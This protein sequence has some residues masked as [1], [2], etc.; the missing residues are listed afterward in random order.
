MLLY[1]NQDLQRLVEQPLNEQP[2]A[3]IKSPRNAVSPIEFQFVRNGIIIDPDPDYTSGSLT[4]GYWYKTTVHSAG[5]FTSVSSTGASANA[6]NAVWQAIGT[7][8]TSWGGDTLKRCDSSGELFSLRWTVKDDQDFNGDTLAY[9]TTFTKYGTGTSTIYRGVTNYNTTGINTLLGIGSG[10]GEVQTILMAELKWYGAQADKTNWI[11]LYLRNDIYKTGDGVPVSGETLYVT[12]VNSK[13]GVVTLAGSGSVTITESP[14]GTFTFTSSASSS[15]DVYTYTDNTFTGD[16]TIGN[17][18]IQPDDG[19]GV[20]QITADAGAGAGGA[21]RA[22]SGVLYV[23]GVDWGVFNFSTGLISG[24][25]LGG[26]IDLAAQVF[27]GTWQTGEWD[28]TFLGL[29][30]GG[31]VRARVQASDDASTTGHRFM[32]FGL[33]TTCGVNGGIATTSTDTANALFIE[34]NYFDNNGSI[35]GECYLQNGGSERSFNAQYAQTSTA[36][37]ATLVAGTVTLSS[38]SI[39]DF[40]RDHTGAALI[41][42]RFKFSGLVG[43]SQGAGTLANGTWYYVKT[44]PTANSFTFSTGVG[45]TGTTVTGSATAANG[46]VQRGGYGNISLAGPVTITA[47][48]YDDPNT[49]SDTALEIKNDKASHSLEV[50]L[51]NDAGNGTILNFSAAFRMGYDWGGGLGTTPDTLFFISP[52]QTGN[53][54]AFQMQSDDRV[55]IGYTTPH[56][57]AGALDVNGTVTATAFSGSGAGL[58]FGANVAAFLA[59]P[60]SA[61]LAAALTDESG[62]GGVVF[63]VAPTVE[64]PVIT[65]ASGAATLTTGTAPGLPDQ[66]FIF[67][68]G[69]SNSTTDPKISVAGTGTDISINIIPKGAGYLQVNTEAVLTDENS[70]TVANKTMSGASNTFT[71][72]PISTAISGLGTGIATALAVNTGSAGA[73]VLFNGALGTPSS[74]T[75]TNCTFP[76]LNQSTTGSAASISISGQSGLVT[77]TGLASTN[78]IKTVRDAADTILELGGSYT[79]TGTWTNM[80]L[81][82]PALGTPSAIVLT[83]ATG[84]PTGI[85]LTKAQLNTIVSDD[86]PAYVG[87]ANTFTAAQTFTGVIT[88]NLSAIALL[89]SIHT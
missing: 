40:V 77:L 20:A 31:V 74:G 27:D 50:L 71:N 57:A 80:V 14:S 68:P 54:P 15:G 37:I 26:S 82:T 46:T 53:H 72:I 79:P 78:R 10:T 76:T 62:T 23:Q 7:T 69:S 60:T 34:T 73:P 86:D 85:S 59:T 47:S 63:S 11:P 56:T 48:N 8:P 35:V 88:S 84:S 44:V 36:P 65:T 28:S 67:T 25:I 81:V 12:S 70:L 29:L 42:L 4:I 6:T 2:L 61:N 18:F 51:R 38:H 66:Y 49:T 33:N 13:G 22:E 24:Q 19:T 9:T 32:S 43:I 55:S 21:L 89:T 45:G 16:Q 58:T 39:T 75:L 87:T 1:V 17:L 30:S 5:V 52:R 41:G 83:N 3:A 64:A